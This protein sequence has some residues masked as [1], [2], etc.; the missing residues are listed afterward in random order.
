MLCFSSQTEVEG[1]NV[2]T[3]VRALARHRVVAVAMGSQHS[4]VIVEAGHVYMFG[5]NTEGQLG[6]GN[7]KAFHAPMEMKS[8]A[9]ISVNVRLA[10]FDSNDDNDVGG[11]NVGL[12]PISSV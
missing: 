8:L 9:H 12:F 1:R 5:R 4:A 7:I 6:T 2:P 10:S 11:C 3:P